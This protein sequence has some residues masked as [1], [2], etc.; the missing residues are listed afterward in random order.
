MRPEEWRQLRDLRLSA[1]AD[2]PDAF[3]ATLAEERERPDADWRRWARDGARGRREVTFVA[4]EGGWA[5]RGLAIGFVHPVKPDT[6]VV[7][8]MWVAPSARRQGAARQ[9]LEAVAAWATGVG[10]ARLELWVTDANDAAEALY[11]AAGFAPTGD[12]QPLASNPALGQTLL[13]RPC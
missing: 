4:T 1:L 5:W 7:G 11:R 2:A 10:A 8:A 9:L 12:R 3:A 6:V 13:E